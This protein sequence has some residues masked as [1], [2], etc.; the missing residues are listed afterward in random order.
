MSQPS[1][2]AHPDGPPPGLPCTHR[3]AVLPE[4]I[5]Y[6]G[7]MNVAYYVVLLDHGADGF[8][9]LVGMGGEFMKRHQLSTF[10]IDARIVYRRELMVNAP[11]N[12]Y[13]HLLDHD[14]KRMQ[15][16]NYLAHA[17]EGWFAAYS[18][19]VYV[20]I[21]LKTRR[22]ARFRPEIMAQIAELYAAH[23]LI[24]RPAALERPFGLG[25]PAASAS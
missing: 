11:V 12:C 14:E 18:E 9:D 24:P 21:D 3:G 20:Q 6:N 2:G 16:G 22:S 23:R 13:S 8:I 15:V 5:D 7:H 1:S 19:W 17:E 10:A 25:R 4:W